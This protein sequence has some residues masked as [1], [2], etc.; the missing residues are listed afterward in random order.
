MD[1]KDNILAVQKV[2]LEAG[3]PVYFDDA[4]CKFFLSGHHMTGIACIGKYDADGQR[5]VVSIGY[6]AEQGD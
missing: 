4:A 2:Y 6:D 5:T 1:E 3:K